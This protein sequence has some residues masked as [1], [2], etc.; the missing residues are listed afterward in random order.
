[1]INSLDLFVDFL[2]I[3]ILFGFGYYS[4]IFFILRWVLNKKDKIL[5]FDKYACNLI[6]YSGIIYF[7][8]WVSSVFLYYFNVT[9]PL[10]KEEFVR[11]LTGKYSF[12]IWLQ[13]VFWLT[14]TQLLRFNFFKNSIIFRILMSLSFLI[15]FER[16]V[17]LVISIH[18][19][20]LPSSWYFGFSWGELILTIPLRILEFIIVVL[21]FMFSS[22]YIRGLVIKRSVNG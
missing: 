14:I 20:Y 6:V 1:M 3:D 4:I 18:R 12:G 8:M 11:R 7:L 19:D 13:P 16:F 21:I 9:S 17:I 2:R 5:T 10:E 15:T 22:K